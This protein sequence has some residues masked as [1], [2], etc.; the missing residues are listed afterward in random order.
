MLFSDW[1]IGHQTVGIHFKCL[2][3]KSGL[4]FKDRS[5]GVYV[6]MCL[7]CESTAANLQS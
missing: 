7:L 4:N 6:F 3:L 5:I 2:E 1:L